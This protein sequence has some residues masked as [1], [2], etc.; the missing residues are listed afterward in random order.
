M[1]ATVIY[2]R[3]SSGKTQTWQQEIHPDGDKY[4]TISG[5]SDGKQVIA[6]WTQVE[7][8]NI[9][10]ANETS[11][12]EQCRLD[13]ESNYRKKLA[14]GKYHTEENDIDNATF[15]APMLAKDWH[16]YSDEN[17]FGYSQPK[18]DGVRC[19]LKADGMWSRNGKPI[20]SCPHII[21]AFE[22]W[23]QKNPDTIFDGELYSDKLSDN[24]EKLISVARQQKPTEEDFDLSKQYLKIHMYDYP[25]V[26]E[27]FHERSLH[28]KITYN[29]MFAK[30]QRMVAELVETVQI[31]SSDHRDA[32]YGKYMELGYEGQ[33][34]RAS[35]AKYKAGRQK[36]LTKRKEFLD[37][38]FELLGVTEGQGN[39]AGY[40]KSVRIRVEGDLEQ[41]CG[42]RGNRAF[43]KKLLEEKDKY[44]SGDVT[45]RF[46]RKTGTGRL[47]FPVAI[48]FYPGK[49]D[50]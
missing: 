15:F 35:I 8:K 18:L 16:D 19:I 4:R 28:L 42:I 47:L 32:L 44:I 21:E 45:V 22:P 13:V 46:Q 50:I 12:T 38:E 48:A 41:D 5:Q 43:C 9:G 49:R 2:K 29:T 39:W 20:V 7:G 40:A 24:F 31:E 37:S 17:I 14:Q 34:L 1:S 6:K 23:F 25:S 30:E 11:A 26:D 3:T 36:Q 27:L 33:M 10:K